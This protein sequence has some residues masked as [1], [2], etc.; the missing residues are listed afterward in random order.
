MATRWL[1]QRSTG[2]LRLRRRHHT[3]TTVMHD[4]DDG[5]AGALAPVG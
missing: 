3:L 1:R 5:P 2:E 4:D